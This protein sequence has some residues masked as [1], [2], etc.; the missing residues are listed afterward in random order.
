LPRTLIAVARS[1]VVMVVIGMIFHFGSALF[2]RPFSNDP[3][4]Y[5]MAAGML[6]LLAPFMFFDGIQMV[7]VYALR[8]LGDQVAAGVNGIIAFFCVT[9][10][11]GWWL[12]RN[13]YGPDALIY[14]SAAGMIVAAILQTLRMWV[15]SC[16]SS[17]RSSG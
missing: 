7:L 4:V 6:A 1:T 14:A 16:R 8:S 2:V 13:G 5:A 11:L 15:I 9:G 3:A 10:G 12:V 17:S